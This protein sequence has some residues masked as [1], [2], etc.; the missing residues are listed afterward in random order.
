MP[1]SVCTGLNVDNVHFGH[2]KDALSKKQS[3]AGSE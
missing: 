3:K 2:D 1:K